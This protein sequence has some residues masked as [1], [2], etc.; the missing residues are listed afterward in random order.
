[1]I[2]K[3]FKKLNEATSPELLGE[4]E[5][6]KLEDAILDEELG[7]PQKRGGWAKFNTNQVDTTSNVSSLHEV[8]TSSGA[9]YLLA[10]INGKLRKSLAGT[11]TWDDV[12]DKGTPPYR[13]QAYADKFIFT[14]GN[15]APFIVSGA[16]LGTVTDLE[17]TAPDVSLV[18]T[19]LYN[20]TTSGWLTNNSYY[21]WIIVYA[22]DDGTISP[23]SQPI[24]VLCTRTAVGFNNLPVSTDARVTHRYI[25]RTKTN[26]DTFYFHSDLDNIKTTWADNTPDTELGSETFSYLNLPKTAKYISLHKERI[27]LGNLTKL[28]KC[29]VTPA[30]SKSADLTV[31]GYYEGLG[32]NPSF[33]NYNNGY[34]NSAAYAAGT[35]TT[36]TYTYRTIYYDSEGLMSDVVDSNSVAIDTVADPT[37]R[38]IK[39]Y[40]IPRIEEGYDAVSRAEIYRKKD[41]GNYELIYS[42]N[43]QRASASFTSATE[44]NDTG[45][46]ATTTYAT[47][48]TTD[49][50]KCS[51]AFA[52]IGTPSVF[53]LEDIRNIFPDDGDEITGIYDDQDGILIYKVRSICKIYTNGAPDNWRLVKVVTDIGC[54][55]PNSLLKYG[56]DYAFAHNGE[57]YTYNSGKGYNN[58]GI[59]I[60]DSLSTVTAYH[61]ATADDGWFMFGVTASA[62]TKGYGFLVYDYNVKSWYLLN[63]TTIPYVARIKEQGTDAGTILTSNATYILKYG[64]GTVDTDTGSNIDIVPILR[65]KTFSQG[66]ILN[67][68]RM[69]EFNYLKQDDKSCIITITNPDSNVTNTHTDSTNSTNSTDYKL[70]KEVTGRATDLLKE[71]DKFYIQITGAGLKTFG[72]LTLQTKPIKRGRILQ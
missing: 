56:N 24:N 26:E 47:N 21:K 19:G 45:L 54:D 9:N 59:D 65:T 4:D 31:V 64:D 10:G 51:I 11:G 23:P 49:T 13:M 66:S 29:W 40:D 70:F 16:T 27:V 58:I 32:T 60:W 50:E 35:L 46:T 72:T 43:P 53:K 37:L 8:V 44:F 36:G 71:T 14:D 17:I 52:D 42:Y 3:G 63:T 12:T 48:Q 2:L 39:I 61:C 69:L 41:S 5:L 38:A 28:S 15:V 57:I 25:Y 7:R 33:Y 62:L 55:E 22:T 20:A 68:L 34:K 30:H 1:M 18:E 67:R 6:T